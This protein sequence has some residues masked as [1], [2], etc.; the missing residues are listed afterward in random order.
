MSLQSLILDSAGEVTVQRLRESARAFFFCMQ[1]AAVLSKFGDLKPTVNKKMRVQMSRLQQGVIR[2][3]E[4]F[5]CRT[6]SC[7][8]YSTRK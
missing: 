3:L 6:V 2:V 8:K 5:R 1:V 4:A 7:G